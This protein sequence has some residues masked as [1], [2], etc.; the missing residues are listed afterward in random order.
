MISRSTKAALADLEEAALSLLE[1]WQL[2][3]A[4][5]SHWLGLMLEAAT[6][7]PHGRHA[8]HHV[9]HEQLAVPPEIEVESEQCLFA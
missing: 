2:P 4:V 3:I 6:T 1:F 5:G 7:M 9:P 8:G